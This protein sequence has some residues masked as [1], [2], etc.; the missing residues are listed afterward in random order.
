MFLLR[1]HHLFPLVPVALSLAMGMNAGCLGRA[2]HGP[3]ERAGSTARKAA[4]EPNAGV[5]DIPEVSGF[6][7]VAAISDVHGMFDNLMRLLTATK[8]VTPDGH[9]L[10][11]H[12][13]LIVTGDSIDKGPKALEVIDLWRTLMAEAPA[14]GSRVVV[15]LGNHEAEFLAHPDKKKSAATRDELAAKGLD[16]GELTDNAKPRGRFLRSLPLA[17]RVGKRW[18]F[19]HAGWIPPVPYIDFVTK[20]QAVLRAGDYGSDFLLDSDSILEKKEGSSGAKWWESKDDVKD[21]ESRMTQDGLYGIVFGH[22]PNAFGLE[23]AVG[24]YD[25]TARLI[26]IDSGM[27]PDAGGHP[28]HLLLF[29]APNEL[30]QNIRPTHLFSVGFDDPQSALK[31]Q[32]L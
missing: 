13:L 21:L 11:D 18:L 22:Q 23:N 29:T 32:P 30:S 3:G 17:A 26:K 27:A 14:K 25:K 31:T 16:V 5:I 28:G 4:E 20:A 2:P 6:R 8:L 7:Q 10:A 9:W 19:C 1:R 12:T 15:L 24:L